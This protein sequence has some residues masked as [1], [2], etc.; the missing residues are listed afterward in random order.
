MGP[1]FFL[2]PPREEVD[3][4]YQNG[5]KIRQKGLFG[6]FVIVVLESPSQEHGTVYHLEIFE[7]NIRAFGWFGH[8]K[9]RMEKVLAKAEEKVTKDELMKFVD[10]IK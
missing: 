10:N 8:D 7:K 1:Q 2:K 4:V 3:F 9:K 6:N 5:E